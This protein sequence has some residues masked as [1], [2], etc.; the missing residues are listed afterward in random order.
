MSYTI[1]ILNAI[2]NTASIEYAARVPAATIANITAVGNAITSY[3]PILNEF[4]STLVEK[5]GL[6]VFVNKMAT[7]KLARFKKGDL[8]HGVDIEEIFI[9][10]AHAEGTYD[11]TSINVFGKRA[12]DI[13]VMYH[14]R[15]RLDDYTVTVSDQQVRTAF[16]TETGVTELLT[17]IVNSMY[18]GSNYDEYVIMKELIASYEA[19]YFDY[20][21]SAITDQASAKE[22]LKTIRKAS[23]DMSYFSKIYNKSG[24]MQQT[25]KGDAVLLMNKDVTA[26]ISVEALASA[27][28]LGKMDI[29]P[30]IIELDDFGS[31]TDT[32]AILVDKRFFMVY[33]TLRTV[34]SA[35]NP[36]AM[37]TNYFLH[38]QQVLSLSEFQNAV[39]FTTVPKI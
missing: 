28:N 10:M 24:V 34:E 5:I 7:N 30:E 38:I 25:E 22:F 37:H 32:Y 21:V 39:R 31:M 1:E 16:I 2:R 6:T 15:N 4:T 11:P 20:G 9:E 12:N 19:N 29:Q 26:E 13:K 35:R 33:D 23:S 14:R 3:V 8:P 18:S 27:F 17:A 36:K